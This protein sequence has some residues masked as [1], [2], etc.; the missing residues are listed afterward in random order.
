VPLATTRRSGLVDQVIEQMRAAI[1]ECEWPVGERIPPEPELVSVLGVGRNT[2]REAVRAL[3]HTGLLEVRQGDGTF[4][5]ATSELSGALRRMCGSELRDVLEVR[6]VIEVEGARLAAS[7]RTGDE[8]AA[9]TTSLAQ[10]DKAGDDKDIETFVVTDAEFHRHVVAASHNRL[11]I[12]LYRGLDETIEASVAETARQDIR[13][14]HMVSHQGILDA[15]ADGDP[16]G[17]ADAAGTF[18]AELLRRHSP[19]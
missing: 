6:R 13:D 19:S 18:F 15:I 9:M 2:V 7:R 10:R 11:L 5:R 4:V 1:A 3:A 14:D 16:A 17:A 12:E 8:L